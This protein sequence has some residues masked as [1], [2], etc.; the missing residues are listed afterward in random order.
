[1]PVE[2]LM[3]DG[4]VL[5]VGTTA[6]Y[7][8]LIDRR[9]PRR[10]FFL[11]D[12][13]E[14]RRARETAPSDNPEIL[15]A[16]TDPVAALEAVKAHLER[17]KLSLSGITS[18]D[19]ESME[20]AAFLAERFGLA[21]QRLETIRIVRDK[22]RTK[23]IWQ[24]HGVECPCSAMVTTEPELMSFADRVGYPVVLKPLT[25]SGSELTFKCNNR[26]ECLRLFRQVVVGLER[27]SGSRMFAPSSSAVEG[28]DPL[29]VVVAEEWVEGPEFSCDFIIED[30][31]VRI[32]RI[33]GKVPSGRLTFGTTFAYLLPA[34]LPDGWDEIRLA[35]Q[36]HEAASALGIER[37][38][39]M[40]DFIV[41]DG[42]PCFLELTP[43]PG[44][45]CLPPLILRSCGLDMLG[46]ALDFAERKAITIP[47]ASAW[48]RLVGVRAFAKTEGKI[49]R[50]D[51]TAVMAQ[52][53][54]VE[55]YL[56]R[57]P[58]HVVKLP[59]EDYDS[60]LLGHIVFR[61]T[62]HLYPMIEQEGEA[63]V[64]RL[65]VEIENRHDQKLRGLSPANGR[66]AE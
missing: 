31:A 51:T 65:V 33:A 13:E 58:G 15:C 63:L 61:P 43:R 29:S 7:I 32:I 4:R 49:I 47:P 39:G 25:G 54:V 5:V 34:I 62:S 3:P 12:P 38:I 53:T 2:R 28:I 66:T 41:R 6:D 30:G 17:T 21:Y 45:D 22:S 57:A 23:E 8:D 46:L 56:K 35:Q 18:F 52:P 37:A 27:R 36:L 9:F 60:W 24:K 11:T 10:A 26:D 42:R 16:L 50:Q 20:L 48:T 1:M 59:P 19:C 55:C 44:G 40:I 64:S 14:R